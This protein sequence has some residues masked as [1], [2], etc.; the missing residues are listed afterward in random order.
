M[1]IDD[2]KNALQS[3][4]LATTAGAALMSTDAAL[5]GGCDSC[6]PGCSTCQTCN[7]GGSN[8]SSERTNVAVDVGVSLAK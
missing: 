8:D 7:S 3:A 4:G 1:K 6:D 2:L 5:A